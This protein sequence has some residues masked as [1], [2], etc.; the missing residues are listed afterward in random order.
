MPNS[1]TLEYAE[2]KYVIA[3]GASTAAIASQNATPFFQ[4][5]SLAKRLAADREH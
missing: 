4:H 2:E 3:D 5:I 1:L